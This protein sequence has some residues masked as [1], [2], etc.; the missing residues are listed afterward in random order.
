MRRGLRAVDQHHGAGGV[1]GRYDDLE[2]HDRAERVG[3]V[4]KRDQLRAAQ[5]GLE[6]VEAKVAARV[7]FDEA[8]LGAGLGGQQLPRHEI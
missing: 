6:I 5:L 1:S 3:D 2:R 8:Q 7:D 4:R